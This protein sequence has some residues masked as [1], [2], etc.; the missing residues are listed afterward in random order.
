MVLGLPRA[1]SSGPLPRLLVDF[2]LPEKAGMTEAISFVHHKMSK[3]GYPMYYDRIGRV[4]VAKLKRV[5]TT[6]RLL[7]Y[8]AWYQEVTSVVRLPAASLAAGR[9]ITT[10]VYV[11]DMTGFHIGMFTSEPRAVLNAVAKIGAD[12]YPQTMEYTFI[13]NAPWTFRTVWAFVGPLLDERIRSRIHILGGPAQYLPKLLE[14]AD[15]RDLPSFIGGQ[16][17]SIDFVHEVGPWAPHL[18]TLG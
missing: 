17:E 5:L 6:E 15:E 3:Q 11:I 16:D 2:R 10:S 14:F 13:I 1:S 4:D 8:V 18:P 7:T 12:Q 9:L